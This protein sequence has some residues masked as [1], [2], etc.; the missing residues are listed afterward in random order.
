MSST[1]W[2]E[3]S[4]ASRMIAPRKRH[5]APHQLAR[6]TETPEAE[7]PNLVLDDPRELGDAYLQR[8]ARRRPHQIE[9][10]HRTAGVDVASRTR[11]LEATGCNSQ[12][13]ST[14]TTTAGGAASRWRMPN[15]ARSPCRG[16]RRS[17]RSTTSAPADRASAAV[18]SL[19]LSATTSTRSP[20]ASCARRAR[21]V[22]P[23]PA[24]S[25]CAGTRTATCGRDVVGNASR[26]SST[27]VRQHGRASTC[28]QQHA[29]RHEQ[30][31]GDDSQRGAEQILR[32]R[33]S[34]RTAPPN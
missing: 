28:T 22:A 21:K 23:M 4:G 18:S 3:A 32:A 14:I 11:L 33:R 6:Q 8:R 31:D 12:S 27:R 2:A 29:G 13:A 15:R 7:R 26:T 19:Q 30:H 20:G 10:L 16:A 25:S 34:R 1:M 24:A 9:R 17:T 5:P